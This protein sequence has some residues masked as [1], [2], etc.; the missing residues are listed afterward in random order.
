MGL[1][2]KAVELPCTC[3]KWF[4][5]IANYLGDI[6]NNV[7][8]ISPPIKGALEW[9]GSFGSLGPGSKPKC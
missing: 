1:G 2:L 8:N 7:G 9:T 6:T 4:G 3:T 5:C